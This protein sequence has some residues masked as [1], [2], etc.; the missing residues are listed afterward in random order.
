MVKLGI[1]ILRGQANVETEKED[2]ERMGQ[3]CILRLTV[4]MG[5]RL[6]SA[7]KDWEPRCG[8]RTQTKQRK[9]I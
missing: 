7:S 9:W 6:Q 1:R 2:Y 4:A 5:G 3:W 8:C